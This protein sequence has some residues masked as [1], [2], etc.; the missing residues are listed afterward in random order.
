MA[1]QN[2]TKR[3]PSGIRCYLFP[4]TF[5][6]DV[7]FENEFKEETRSSE[8]WRER[9]R[10]KE[11]RIEGKRGSDL[12]SLGKC[13]NEFPLAVY[14]NEIPSSGEAF[15]QPDRTVSTPLPLLPFLRRLI[16]LC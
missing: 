4:L 1:G 7:S 3:T 16:A 2:F 15:N 8:E 14:I 5:L 13:E 6:F 12:L 9:E 10:E 11:E